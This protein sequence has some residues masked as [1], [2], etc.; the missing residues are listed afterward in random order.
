MPRKTRKAHTDYRSFLYNNFPYE[1]THPDRLATLA[2]LHGLHT[3]P[4]DRCRVLELGCGLGGNLIGLAV[5]LP[6]STFVGVDLS[7]EQIA[8][9][10][11]DA[12]ALSL[13]NLTLYA[14]DIRAVDESLGLFDYII[15]HGIFSWVPEEVQAAILRVC[16]E[17]LAQNGVAY[18]SFNTFPGWHMRGMVRDMLRREAGDSDS[19]ADR[20]QRGRNLLGL[21]DSLPPSGSPSQAFLR[22]EVN[23]LNSLGDEYLYYEHLVDINRP[24]YFRDFAIDAAK[25]GLSYLT[26][27]H[28]PSVYPGRFEADSLAAIEERSDDFIDREQLADYLEIR[29]FRRALLCH[30]GAPIERKLSWERVV[31]LYVSTDL[32]PLGEEFDL[33]GE[34]GVDFQ[35]PSGRGV[36]ATL[37]LLKAGLLDLHALAP[38]R[39]SLRE[40]CRLARTRLGRPAD[41]PAPPVDVEALAANMLDMFVLGYATL[42]SLPLDFVTEVS[43]RPRTTVLARW[44][45]KEVR[46]GCTNLLHESVSV[47]NLDRAILSRLDGTR[48]HAALVDGVLEDIRD[49][50]LSLTVDDQP[51]ADRELVADLTEQKLR[52]LARCAFFIA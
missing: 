3:P 47:D 49:Q 29:F 23:L 38:G 13:R 40:L 1:E 44:Q 33:Q 32:V 51:V 31:D 30:A 43:E 4:P 8:A 25:A 15:C 18:I 6:N 12:R 27:A 36:S 14:R 39:V 7:P 26:D 9:A 10:K 20:V 5:A 46:Q 22:G 21:L 11:A 52:R 45:A 50:K 37:P 28:Y 16:R 42:F 17:N 2:H 48:D 41:E 35:N 34:A 19:A 24:Q